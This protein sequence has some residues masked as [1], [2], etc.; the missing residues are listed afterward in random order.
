MRLEVLVDDRNFIS[1][2][3]SYMDLFTPGRSAGAGS[4]QSPARNFGH[5]LYL[6]QLISMSLHSSPPHQ[7][8]L[9]LLLTSV[10]A[11]DRNWRLYCPSNQSTCY[12]LLFILLEK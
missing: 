12:A 10:A 4:V 11:M 8:A 1:K 6:E 7:L 9:L 5:H 3:A 2:W